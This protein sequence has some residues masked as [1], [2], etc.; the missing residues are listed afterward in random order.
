MEGSWRICRD[1]VQDVG[2]LLQLLLAGLV[3]LRLGLL[4]GQL[5][6]SLGIADDGPAAYS[7]GL[8]LSLL[9]QILRRVHLSYSSFQLLQ[10]GLDLVDSR[11]E[12]F[13]EERLI[14]AR[15]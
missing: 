14:V 15:R 10:L 4:S 5:S 6:V 9:L 3:F 2:Q 12:A 11:L 13:L 1:P 7:H 8:P